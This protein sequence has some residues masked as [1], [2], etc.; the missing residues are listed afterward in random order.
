[1]EHD[2]PGHTIATTRPT[3]LPD[4][5][6]VCCYLPPVTQIPPGWHPDP[7]GQQPG[8]PPQLRWWDGT[9]WTDHL[10]PA[11]PQQPAPTVG[12]GQVGQPT[13][14]GTQPYAGQPYAPVAGLDVPTTPDG[15]RLAGW[16]WRVLA[17][18]I[19][20]LVIGVA[21][22]VV[23]FPAQAGMQDDLRVLQDEMQRRLDANPDDTGALGDYFHG[24][25]DVFHDHALA[26]SLPGIVIGALYFGILLRWKGAT[27]GMLATGLRVRLRE[28]PGQLPWSTVVVRVTVQVLIYNVLLMVGLLSGSLALL[29]LLVAALTIFQFLNYLWPLW[30][31]KKQALHDK[32]ARTNVVKVR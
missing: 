27:L 20:G 11:Q 29:G 3:L 4:S 6:D 1:V 25:V 10:A 18:V 22:S 28:R 5:G 2:W 23:S 13:P 30:D 26:L 12:W 16:W 15:Q 32:A 14:Q 21:G 17:Y 7:A 19:D 8:Q 31:S 24:M 9:Q